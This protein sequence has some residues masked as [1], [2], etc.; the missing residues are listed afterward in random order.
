MV[1]L[2]SSRSHDPTAAFEGGVGLR[3]IPEWKT[4]AVGKD[5]SRERRDGGDPIHIPDVLCEV[6]VFTSDRWF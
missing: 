2:A 1:L 6:P 4:E 3:E 5:E